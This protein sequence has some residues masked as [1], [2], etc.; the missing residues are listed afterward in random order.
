MADDPRLGTLLGQYRLDELIGRGG[1]GVVY[2]AFDTRLERRVAVKIMAPDVASDPAF[3]QRF[4]REARMAAAIDHPNILPIYDTGEVDGVLFIAMRY[5]EGTDLR[6]V[7][8]DGGALPPERAVSLLRQVAGAL[9]AAHARGLVHR[10]VKPANVLMA[11]GS[12]IDEEDHAY[13][14]DF[15]LTKPFNQAE[16]SMTA[17]GQFVGTIDYVAPEQVEGRELDGW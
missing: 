10:D 17:T 6:T 9:A 16:R 11:A 2:L 1:M 5:V 3:R 15:G 12:A 8:M 7:I 14:T 4:E 13:L